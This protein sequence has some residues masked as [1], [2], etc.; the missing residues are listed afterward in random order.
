[1]RQFQAI[2]ICYGYGWSTMEAVYVMVDSQNQGGTKI[3]INTKKKKKT[4][5]ATH[6]F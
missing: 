2:V 6:H 5:P 3:I 1:M 4:E